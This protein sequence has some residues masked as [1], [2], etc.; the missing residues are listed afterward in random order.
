MN[1]KTTLFMTRV[2]VTLNE[3]IHSLNQQNANC[4][5]L[6]HMKKS[7]QWWF[8]VDQCHWSLIMNMTTEMISVFYYL[9]AS[10]LLSEEKKIYTF[11]TQHA[12]KQHKN[13]MSIIGTLGW[14]TKASFRDS[15]LNRFI[16]VQIK[17]HEMSNHL[18][19]GF[20]LSIIHFP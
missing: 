20:I 6:M 12:E 1:R 15:G 19:H 13:N 18:L 4:I 11:S 16:L 7:N 17:S 9:V 8:K 14:I 10:E 5:M 3:N 2:G